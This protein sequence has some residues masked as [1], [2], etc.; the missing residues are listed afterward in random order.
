MKSGLTGIRL[1]ALLIVASIGVASIAMPAAAQ[2]GILRSQI[3][4]TLNAIQNQ[5][6]QAIRPQLVVKNPAGALQSI[7]L[8][9]DG[10]LLAIL[11]ADNSIRVFDL[12]TGLQRVRLSGAASRFRSV[13][14][15]T[16][17]RFILTG[18]DDGTVAVWD[19]A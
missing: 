12:Q 3:N 17:N 11:S 15:T 7:T 1:V 4:P 6:R 13:A 5:I 19:A 9:R 18:S 8:S 14:T 16:D 10:R 2:V